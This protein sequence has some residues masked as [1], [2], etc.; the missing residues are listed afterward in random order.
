M[1]YFPI[2]ERLQSFHYLSRVTMNSPLNIT[3]L[4]SFPPFNSAGEISR[5]GIMY[6]N[7][8]ICLFIHERLT[9]SPQYDKLCYMFGI[10]WVTNLNVILGRLLHVAGLLCPVDLIRKSCIG[11]SHPQV[12]PGNPY[13]HCFPKPLGKFTM[14]SAVLRHTNDIITL[15]ARAMCPFTFL[16]IERSEKWHL[17][18]FFPSLG[19]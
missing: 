3:G 5:R 15:P 9:R 13:C 19:Y 12:D 14:Q 10:A 7:I 11:S 8:L 1:N 18:Y 2:L 6:F 16:G 4:I 17:I